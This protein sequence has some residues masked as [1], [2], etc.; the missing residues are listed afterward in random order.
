[1][2]V[3]LVTIVGEVHRVPTISFFSAWDPR[4]GESEKEE[5]RGQARG[6]FL[7][8]SDLHRGHYSRDD[9]VIRYARSHDA[10]F[11]V[12][13]EERRSR[14]RF[15]PPSSFASRRRCRRTCKHP[16]VVSQDARVRPASVLCTR[17]KDGQAPLQPPETLNK[18]VACTFLNWIKKLSG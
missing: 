9:V 13:C 5:E 6:I 7:S 3:S 12:N 8:G 4:E 18:L 1:M 17:L 10:A 15:I 16:T 2:I 14:S 11:D